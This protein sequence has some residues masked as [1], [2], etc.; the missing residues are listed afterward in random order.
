MNQQEISELKKELTQK[1]NYTV[2][3]LCKLVTVLRSEWGCPWDK[4][5]THKSLRSDIIEEAYEVIEAIDCD[6]PEMMR[7]ELGD[8]LLQV[9]FHVNIEEDKNNFTLTDVTTELCQKLIVRHP[10]VFG[11]V[12][13]NTAE[14]VLKNWDSIKKETKHQTTFTETLQAVPD[15]FPSLMRSAKLGKRAFRAGVKIDYAQQAKKNAELLENTLKE[16]DREKQTAVIGNL[17][18]CISNMARELDI[19]PE[20]ALADAG[21]QFTANFEKTEQAV[22]NDGKSFEQLGEDIINF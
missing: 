3:D 16:N 1:T 22:I 5:Q 7:E 13:A 19:D 10:H 14:Q 2:D 4:V 17:L 12:N 20:Q 8:L 11:D 6:S 15:V 18:F 9:A 21:K